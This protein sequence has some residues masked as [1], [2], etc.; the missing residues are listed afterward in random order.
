MNTKD[1]DNLRRSN[2]NPRPYE[3]ASTRLVQ[4]AHIY[5]TLNTNRN[6]PHLLP[7]ID[8]LTTKWSATE[9][10]R[11]LPLVGV[12]SILPKGWLYTFRILHF[13]GILQMF[14]RNTPQNMKHSRYSFHISCKF[15]ALLMPQK[16]K[17]RNPLIFRTRI[18][19]TLFPGVT[20]ISGTFYPSILTWNQIEKFRIK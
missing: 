11:K 8:V 9:C 12:P 14:S 4:I 19:M 13:L 17:P 20:F 1:R 3:A 7:H 16:N 2:T 6:R 15:C 18:L 5:H 10:I